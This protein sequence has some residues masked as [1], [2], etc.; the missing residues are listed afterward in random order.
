MSYDSLRDFLDRLERDGS[1]VRVKEPVATRL[2]MTEIARRL[3]AK[4]GPAVLFENPV[5]DDG[6][7]ATMP[8]LVNLFGTL[9]RMAAG[10]GLRPDELPR[11]GRMLASLNQPAPLE[12]IADAIDRLPLL[13]K[14]MAMAP[15]HIRKPAPCQEQ[16]LRGKEVDLTRLPV[17]SCWPG[18]PAPLIAWSVVVTKGPGD[19]PADGVNL[20][21]Y[22]MQVL[23]RNRAVIRWLPHRGGAQHFRRWTMANSAPMPV[24]VAVG[25]DP[26]VLIAATTPV[27]DTM[28]EYTFAGLMRSKRVDVV[29]SIT[30][31]LPV[32]S[33]AEIILE[34]TVDPNDMAMEGPYGDHTGYFNAMEPFP[35]MTI[36]AMTMRDAPL[37]LSTFIGRPPDE[38]STLA[39][40]LNE[41]F[42]PLIIQQFPEIVDF[43]L[44]PEGCS[45]RIAVVSIKKAY[46]GHARRL[47]MGIWSALRQFTYTKF[48][49]VVDDDIDTRDWRDVMWAVSTRMDPVRDIVTIENT[50]IDY[51]DFASPEPG[52]GGKL[53]LDATLKIPPEVHRRQGTPIRM[54]ESIIQRIDDI[55]RRLGLD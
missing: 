9:E 49:I 24:S 48:V 26:A 43:W 6:A 4:S 36:T 7:P 12:G 25:C 34:G 30:N 13:K 38:A 3:I 8:V 17:M 54:D 39:L 44:P 5:D 51:L 41:V 35:A 19:D 2:E 42:K 32:P 37:Y 22:R 31:D 40:G 1:L 16:V 52:L 14:I 50:P 23:S 15:R 21:V 11:L 55:W 29:K 33:T 20:G 45:Y 10:L 53:G 27:P 18:E 28:S 47:M 46:P